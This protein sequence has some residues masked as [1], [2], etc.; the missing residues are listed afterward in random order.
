LLNKNKKTIESVYSKDK[1]VFNEKYL[2]W[3]YTFERVAILIAS[4]LLP[5]RISANF[6]SVISLIFG[7]LGCLLIAID[8]QGSFLL[9]IIFVIIWQILDDV[10]GHIARA[11]ESTL[12]G[13]YLDDCGANIM[14]AFFFMAL[15]LIF[16]S[17]EDNGTKLLND[18]LGNQLLSS[19][20][21]TLLGFSSALFLS[22]QAIISFHHKV[23]S[24]GAHKKYKKSLSHKNNKNF[25]N[26]IINSYKYLVSNFLEFPGFLVPLVFISY[27]AGY[28][29]I[30]LFFVAIFNFINLL[31]K[32]FTVAISLGK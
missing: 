1:K 18:I 23:L 15:G 22:L 5:Y 11:K 14:Y 30:L 21:F 28:L 16:I 29:S 12:L 4:Y 19:F 8:P 6:V 13:K 27:I 32:Y 2:W 31:I 20:I 9:G 3:H 26:I 25:T 17:S 7:L 24:D 10:D